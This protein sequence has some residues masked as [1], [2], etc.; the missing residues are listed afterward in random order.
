M[1]NSTQL[2]ALS[3]RELLAESRLYEAK[4]TDDPAGLNFTSATATGLKALNDSFEA[5]LD[6]HDASEA[7]QEADRVTKDDWHDKVL[8]E[9]RRQRNIAYADTTI[10][11]EMLAGFGLPPRDATKTETPAPTTAPTGR[12]EYGKLK[13]TIHFRDS[14]TPDR[15]AKPK[16]VRGCE[17]WRYIGTTPPTTENDL[18]YVATDSDSPY[19]AFYEMQ[20]ANKIVYYTLRW[21]SNNG[22]TGEW[23]ETI[24]ATI[25]G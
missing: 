17:I 14:A 15:K 20:D 2:G 4:L 11:K 18:S 1:L 16:G 3:D 21:V 12:V 5:S 13:H 24:Q 8:N 25:N 22:E 7:A 19:V 23:S 9:L 10:T 6:A